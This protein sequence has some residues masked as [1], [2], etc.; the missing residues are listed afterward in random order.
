MLPSR[1]SRVAALMAASAIVLLAV[2][3]L[4]Y[5]AVLAAAYWRQEALLFQPDVLAA[6]HAFVEMPDV[7]E[8]RIAV[9]GAVLDALHLKLPH[10]KG[11][12]FFL[13]GNAGSLASWFVNT[14]FYRRANFDLFMID[15]R[16]Y[17]KSTGR[18]DSEAQL[19]ADV[20][21]AWDTIAP[22]YAGMR[23]VIYG[24]SLG[25]DLAAVLAARAQPDLTIL[26]SPYWSMTD[27]ARLHYPLLPA[28]LLRYPL[29]TFREVARIEQPILLL[30]GDRDELIPLAHA[31]RL[32]ALNPRATLVAVPG[33]GHG[34]L[35]EFGAYTEAIAA[36]LDALPPP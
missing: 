3:A 30:H 29:E 22:R 25:S 2:L 6:D 28:A 12:V 21:R 1:G 15:Y 31:R 34:D 19:H 33:A 16:G 10:P 36:A 11:V 4:L 9:D 18:I 27:L 7:T 23:R 14:P 35:Q 32:R 26:A 20:A 17:G 13:H 24:R 8:V 5:A